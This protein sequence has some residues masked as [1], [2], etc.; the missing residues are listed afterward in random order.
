MKR[1]VA[2]S[3]S[4]GVEVLVHHSEAPDD[5]TP[6]NDPP[7]WAPG[8]FEWGYE[9]QGPRRLAYAILADLI[10]DRFGDAFMKEVVSK[11]SPIEDHRKVV[12][13]Q[14]EHILNWLRSKLSQV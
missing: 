7:G 3:T 5:A 6:L 14:E 9:G 12:V 4:A 8:Q 13:F 10:A 11:T 2:E 1:Y